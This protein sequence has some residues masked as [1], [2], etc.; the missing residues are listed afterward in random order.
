MSLT[1][2][3]VAAVRRAGGGTME[4]GFEVPQ[5]VTSPPDILEHQ[6]ISKLTDIIPGQKEGQITLHIQDTPRNL[7]RAKMFTSCKF[8]IKIIVLAIA[9]PTH[10]FIQS[11]WPVSAGKVLYFSY[12]QMYRNK[13]KEDTFKLPNIFFQYYLSQFCFFSHDLWK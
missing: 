13:D 3:S 1:H 11:H 5:G 6:K 10:K 8:I 12:S 2:S 4:I 7:Y 9:K